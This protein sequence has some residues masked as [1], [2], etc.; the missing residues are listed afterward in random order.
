MPRPSPAHAPLGYTGFVVIIAALM[1]LNAMAID[2]MLPALPD[3]AREFDL[4]DPNTAQTVISSYL[5]G[6]GIS[7]LFV[8]VLADRFG[9]KPILLGGLFIYIVGALISLS[10]QSFEALLIAR[11]IMGAGS[12]A[13]RTIANAVARDCYTGR[14]MAQ[15]MSIAMMVFMA[16]PVLAPS[17]GQLILFVAPWQATLAV[18]AGYGVLMSLVCWRLLP[19]TL[20]P[21]HRR[22]LRLGPIATGFATVLRN[23]QAMGYALCSGL[24]MGAMFGFVNS[25]QQVLGEHFGLG[26]WFPA[27]FAMIAF[28]VAISSFVNARLVGRLG[29]RFLSHG[30]VCIYVAL[31][32]AMVL[33][34]ADMPLIAFIVLLAGS[35][36]IVGMTFAN[37]NAIAMEPLGEVA[38]IASSVI[39]AITVLIGA[40]LGFLIGQAYDGT[41]LPMAIGFL[42]AGV[43]TL[44]VLLLTERGRL[45][46]R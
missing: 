15:V 5:L 12:A 30:A 36:F 26:P 8:G 37:F 32:L 40:G 45:F 38:G 27:I 11:V 39:G 21:E 10:T 46:A 19:E 9:R 2:I 28:A 29:M 34:G 4:D 3:L 20:A 43:G 25:A 41:P 22:P 23:G 31:S 35:M 17:I 24:F 13:P 14:D 44:I 16:A 33:L 18:L 7:Q 6:F 42:G 1:A